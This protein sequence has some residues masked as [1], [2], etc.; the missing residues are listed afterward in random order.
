MT[1][2]LLLVVALALGLAPG[3]AAESPDAAPNHPP[4]PVLEALGDAYDA[5]RVV[6]G[7][8]VTHTYRLRNHGTRPLTLTVEPSCGCTTT[9]FDKVIPAGAEGTVTAALETTQQRGH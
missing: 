8:K 4:A 2:G 1:T 6:N 3:A 7:T 5:G 9:A